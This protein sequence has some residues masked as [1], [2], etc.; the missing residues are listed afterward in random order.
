V[1][2]TYMTSS[3]AAPLNKEYIET[4]SPLWCASSSIRSSDCLATS[5]STYIYFGEDARNS[6]VDL[7]IYIGSIPT[8]YLNQVPERLKE[9]FQRIIKDG[10]DM[11]RMAMVIS[12]DER[13]VR[14]L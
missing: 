2:G 9:S 7:P 4:E 6:L 8:A 12:R 11:K 10:I 1:L 3:A 5:S 14:R 13:Q